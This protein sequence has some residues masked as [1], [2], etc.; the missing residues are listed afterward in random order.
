M[1]AYLHRRP[2]TRCMCVGHVSNVCR[3][4][5]GM[6]DR[7]QTLEKVGKN[8]IPR[9]LTSRHYIPQAGIVTS[10]HFL[11]WPSYD[12][13]ICSSGYRV[14]EAIGMQ[15]IHKYEPFFL[16]SHLILKNTFSVSKGDPKSASPILICQNSIYI[17]ADCKM[18]CV[19]TLMSVGILNQTGEHYRSTASI[20]SWNTAVYRHRGFQCPFIISTPRNSVQVRPT[21]PDQRRSA[22][23]LFD[24]VRATWR[25]R[26]RPGWP[27]R[28]AGRDEGQTAEGC[29]RGGPRSVDVVVLAPWVID[30]FP[31]H[32]VDQN[33]RVDDV[34]QLN[35][36]W[37]TTLHA[38]QTTLSLSF[39]Y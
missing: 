6:N 9:F 13:L 15:H 10:L 1:S 35:I 32:E 31:S 36:T 11:S 2:N 30:L 12:C 22:R 27:W 23:E 3:H 18:A 39:I 29:G 20:T 25:R 7:S 17:K 26:P 5:R 38:F 21:G 34:R 37:H 4:L 16:W 14:A 8:K 19:F 28:P 33:A 24:R